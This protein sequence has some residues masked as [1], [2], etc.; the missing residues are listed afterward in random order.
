MKPFNVYDKHIFQNE[1]YFCTLTN[2]SAPALALVVP[3]QM[4]AESTLRKI[5]E[6]FGFQEY[7]AM[8]L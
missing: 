7:N 5:F 1:K 2:P 8:L 4:N 3:R 6:I